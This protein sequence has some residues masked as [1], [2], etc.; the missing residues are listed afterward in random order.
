MGHWVRIYED[1]R[2][3]VSCVFTALKCLYCVVISSA[4]VNLGSCMITLKKNSDYFKKHVTILIY[5]SSM[6]RQVVT[7]FTNDDGVVLS[8]QLLS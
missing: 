3:A 4:M 2:H 5:V 8:T 1:E 6:M 7:V